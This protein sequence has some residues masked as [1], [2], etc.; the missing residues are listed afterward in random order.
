MIRDIFKYISSILLCFIMII[1]S[2][3]IWE[4]F[5]AKTS[6]IENVIAQNNIELI[7][8]QSLNEKDIRFAIINGSYTILN[9]SKYNINTDLVFKLDKSSDLKA[10]DLI[11]Y[12]DDYNCELTYLYQD[13]DQNYDIYLLKRINLFGKEKRTYNIKLAIKE[14]NYNLVKGKNYKYKIEANTLL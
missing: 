12:V 13:S 11:I 7:S 6:V 14:E 4:S 3:F 1:F 5:R 8:G 2:L 9:N 10:D